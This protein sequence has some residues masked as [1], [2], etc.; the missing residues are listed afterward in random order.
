MLFA[1]KIILLFFLVHKKLPNFTKLHKY[2][3]PARPQQGFLKIYLNWFQSVTAWNLHI[4]GDVKHCKKAPCPMSLNINNF[5][6]Y[7]WLKLNQIN[8]SWFLAAYAL[9]ISTSFLCHWFFYIEILFS[10]SF[11]FFISCWFFI[12]ACLERISKNDK[13]TKINYFWS[14]MSH[15]LVASCTKNFLQQDYLQQ[16]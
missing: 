7:Y 1:L 8:F 14:H 16:S 2:W 9:K 5:P 12:Q 4:S 11:L 15:V 3:W 13:F 10:C 6:G